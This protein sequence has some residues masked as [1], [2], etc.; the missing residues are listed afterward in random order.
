MTAFDHIPPLP[1]AAVKSERL[2]CPWCGEHDYHD[3]LDGHNHLACKSC[4]RGFE[5]V[6]GAVD[7]DPVTQ[8]CRSET[9]LKYM[10]AMGITEAM[11]ATYHREQ[12]AGIAV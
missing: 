7:D 9:D 10:D 6:P 12:S 8:G 5:L 11:V 1:T 3:F 4:G 2:P